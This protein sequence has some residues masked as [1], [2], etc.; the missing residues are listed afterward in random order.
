MGRRWTR[1]SLFITAGVVAVAIIAVVALSST[2]G[3]ERATS[4]TSSTDSVSPTDPVTSTSAPPATTASTGP[5]A[6]EPALPAQM[7]ADFSMVAEWGVARMNILDTSAGTFTKDL[8]SG[9]PPTATAHLVLG[10]AELESLYQDL[11]ALDPFSY[12]DRFDPPYA[13]VTEPGV[14]QMVSPTTR[15][16]LQVVAHGLVKDIYWTDDNFSSV[17]AANAL[18]EWFGKVMRAVENTPEYKA[19]PEARGGYA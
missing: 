9:E 13:D 7:P 15:Y 8:V 2:L 11:R 3:C 10:A 14:E 6:H 4:T 12:P 5:E 1:N 17:A 16:H 19:M 18:R